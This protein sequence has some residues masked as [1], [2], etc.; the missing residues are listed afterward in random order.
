MKMTPGS[1]IALLVALA[2]RL[3]APGQSSSWV[4]PSS[5]FLSGAGGAEFR[6]DVR[7]LNQVMS[8]A[9]GAFLRFAYAQDGV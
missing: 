1:L 2:I 6:T 5:A 9:L 8:A 7:I 3:P 4:L